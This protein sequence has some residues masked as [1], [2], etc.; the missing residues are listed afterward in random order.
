[1]GVLRPGTLGPAPVRAGTKWKA[2]GG[3]FFASRCKAKGGGKKLATDVEGDGRGEAGLR[4]DPC[5]SSSRMERPVSG[6]QG[7]RQCVRPSRLTLENGNG[8]ASNRPMHHYPDP[9]CHGHAR[10][11]ARRC[12]CGPVPAP[13]RN[14]PRTTLPNVRRAPPPRCP[15]LMR[16][17]GVSR[18]VYVSP[19]YF[20]RS[21]P[22]LAG[23]GVMATETGAAAGRSRNGRRRPLRQR[24]KPYG[25]NA[26][27][28]RDSG[29]AE[30]AAR[31]ATPQYFPRETGSYQPSQKLLFCDAA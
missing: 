28:K 20:E 31:R 3:S 29:A 26:L 25:G 4:S 1:M 9:C 21:D 5:Q 12:T 6:N 10:P 8:V 27:A 19:P 17:L 15:A 30:S 2:A 23:V 18:P 13:P 7:I 24:L 11:W 22:I 16:T 14:D